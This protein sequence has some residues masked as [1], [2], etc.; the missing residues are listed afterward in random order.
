MI[1]KVFCPQVCPLF[2]A[3]LVGNNDDKHIEMSRYRK[4][5]EIKPQKA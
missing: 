5:N 4:A 2:F 1:A 3:F